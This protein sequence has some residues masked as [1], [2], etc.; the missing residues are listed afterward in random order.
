MKKKLEAGKQSAFQSYDL[1]TIRCDAPL[2]FVPE[3]A[4][5]RPAN[6]G[7]L[8][9]LLSPPGFS[10]ADGADGAG[11]GR[12]RAGFPAAVRQAETVEQ[13]AEE[14]AGGSLRPSGGDRRWRC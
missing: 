6:R 13:V 3:Q 7:L 11:P 4:L 12:G 5:R 14:A 8:R 10:E 1:C 2:D 9:E